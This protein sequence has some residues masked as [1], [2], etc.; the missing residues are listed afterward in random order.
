M[1]RSSKIAECTETLP[2][3]RRSCRRR[4]HRRSACPRY[5]R[6]RCHPRS[7]PPRRR[8]CRLDRGRTRCVRV[9]SVATAACPRLCARGSTSWR[10]RSCWPA[11][12]RRAALRA[13]TRGPSPL[14]PLRRHHRC[15]RRS[16]ARRARRPGQG[17][18]SYRTS[19]KL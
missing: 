1:Y 10:P 6:R 2:D 14:S 3:C 4:G 12:S 16:F 11:A 7:C 18:S 19:A 9:V 13:E 5:H 8:C 17:C 15:Q